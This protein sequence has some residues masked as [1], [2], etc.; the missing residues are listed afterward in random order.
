MRAV[1]IPT[2]GLFSALF[3]TASLAAQQ[4]TVPKG[5]LT[6][7]GNISTANVLGFDHDMY[8]S[9][10]VVDATNVGPARL[11]KGFS[12]RRDG[13][14]PTN[15][16]YAARSVTLSI[17][18][19]HADLGKVPNG[20]IAADTVW[21]K[22]SWVTVLDKAMVLPALANQPATPPAPFSIPLLL[23]SPWAYNGADALAVQLR[24]SPS[25][26]ATDVPYPLDATSTLSFNQGVGEAIGSGC[27]PSGKTAPIVHSSYLDNFGSPG[28]GRWQLILSQGPA[29]APS[30]ALI[31][32]SNPDL[33]FGA[34][35]RLYVN[36]LLVLTTGTTSGTGYLN[37]NLT[38]PNQPAYVGL[39]FYSQMAAYDAGQS[40][41]P[42]A[43]TNGRKTTYPASPSLPAYAAGIVWMGGNAWPSSMRMSRGLSL[44]LG[45][46]W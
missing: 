35:T 3:L 46:T 5:F 7:E 19:A 1:P 24:T 45:M 40:K 36:P 32:A 25:N 23:T 22:T 28:V 39:T 43:L 44:I 20:D 10:T 8:G 4:G 34:C 33:A 42:F 31:G 15:L 26:L 14:T 12:L 6:A 13:D 11:L 18:L 9:W 29:T 37:F 21:R 41:L 16:T 17:R 27:T 30:L 2:P 38:F